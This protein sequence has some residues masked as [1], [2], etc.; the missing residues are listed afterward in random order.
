MKYPSLPGQGFSLDGI[1]FKAL[2]SSNLKHRLSL[3][4]ITKEDT[5]STDSL[6]FKYDLVFLQ[7]NSNN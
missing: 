4:R 7:E 1:H 6:F 3:Q 2:K 5:I